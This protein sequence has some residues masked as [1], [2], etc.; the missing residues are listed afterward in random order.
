MDHLPVCKP[1]GGEDCRLQRVPAG[2]AR[3]CVING[4]SGPSLTWATGTTAR[5]LAALLLTKSSVADPKVRVL[6]KG[7]LTLGL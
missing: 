6:V 3:F 2:L 7:V 5:S 4:A 1:P